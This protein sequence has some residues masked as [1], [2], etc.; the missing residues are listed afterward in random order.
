M[1]KDAA[2]VITMFA[3]LYLVSLL[4]DDEEGSM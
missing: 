3:L 2:I 4:Y 1:L